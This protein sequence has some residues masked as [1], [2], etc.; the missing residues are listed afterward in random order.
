MRF[1]GQ[2]KIKPLKLALETD[3]HIGNP[4]NDEDLQ[5]TV[6]DMN[7]IQQYTLSL[8]LRVMSLSLV[9]INGKTIAKVYWVR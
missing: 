3:S 5:Q 6:C 2:T 4:S 9:E 8:L 1:V 7:Q